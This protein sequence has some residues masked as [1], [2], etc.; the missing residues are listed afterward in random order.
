MKTTRE[1]LCRK[2][3]AMSLAELTR[4]AIAAKLNEFESKDSEGR[5]APGAT[6]YCGYIHEEWS[7]RG[8]TDA[9]WMHDVI[10]AGRAELRRRREANK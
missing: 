7:R 5:Y 4:E 1:A 10:E 8:L 3:A 2:L 9:Q 6:Q